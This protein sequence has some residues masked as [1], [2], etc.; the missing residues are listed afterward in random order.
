MRMT[1][2]IFDETIISIS[3]IFY[4]LVCGFFLYYFTRVVHKPKLY[5]SKN[6]TWHE[7]LK[8]NLKELEKDQWPL[9]WCF[10]PLWQAVFHTLVMKPKKIDFER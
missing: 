4:V 8:S 10:P 2:E 1:L 9:V 3:Q 6:G 5:C 7:T